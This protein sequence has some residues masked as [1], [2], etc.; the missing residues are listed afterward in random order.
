[1]STSDEHVSDFPQIK[2]RLDDIAESVN[3]ESLSLDEVLKLYE[4][5]VSLGLEAS[6]LLEQ[7]V[8][9][10]TEET[11]TDAESSNQAVDA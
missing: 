11:S 2:A 1:M 4:E 7:E 9:S 3:D 5:A 8:L 6:S 10:S